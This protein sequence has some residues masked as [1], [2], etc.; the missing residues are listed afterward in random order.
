MAK[1]KGG[2]PTLMT[3]EIVQKLKEYF[4]YGCSDREA[5]ILCKISK[6]TFYNYQEANPE[7]VEEKEQLK[8]MVILAARKSIIEGN[9]DPKNAMDFMKRKKRKEF[10]DKQEIEAKVTGDVRLTDLFGRN[11]SNQED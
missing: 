2:R 7:F 8:E 10:G 6:S 5:C 1:N 11:N 3:P 4:S 9:K